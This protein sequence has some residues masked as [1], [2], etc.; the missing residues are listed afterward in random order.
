MN[1]K[2]K[3]FTIIE[4]AIALSLSAVVMLAIAYSLSVFLRALD[5]INADVEINQVSS[6]ILG[7]ISFDVRSSD[8]IAPFSTS[9]QLVLKV[10]PESVVYDQSKSKIRRQKSGYAAYLT[11][12]ENIGELSFGYPKEG[13]VK[14][15]LGDK[16]NTMAYVRN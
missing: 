3:G 4:L 9:K 14:I 6:M 10:G 15:S 11:A 7:R 8:G 16:F 1:N 5:K 2:R 13:L 12:G